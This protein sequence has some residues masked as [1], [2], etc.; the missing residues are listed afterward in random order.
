MNPGPGSRLV[1][2]ATITV[3]AAFYVEEKVFQGSSPAACS[4]YHNFISILTF[5][6]KLLLQPSIEGCHKIAFLL[7]IAV[8]TCSKCLL[9]FQTVPFQCKNFKWWSFIVN[10]SF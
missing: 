6:F 9:L 10:T 2:L 4:L 8:L 1:L 3:I 7:P 5:Q